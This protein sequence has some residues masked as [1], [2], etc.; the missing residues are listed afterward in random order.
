MLVSCDEK[1]GAAGCFCSTKHASGE[2]RRVIGIFLCWTGFPV[3]GRGNSENKPGAKNLEN[4]PGNLTNKA[5]ASFF[6]PRKENPT[7]RGCCLTG[8]H[9]TEAGFPVA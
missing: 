2:C 3:P 6:N 8:E 4:A 1:E 9:P 5:D 7:G